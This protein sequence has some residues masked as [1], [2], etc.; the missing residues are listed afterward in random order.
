MHPAPETIAHAVSLLRRGGLVAFPTETV[1]G[2]GAD[3]F[4][5][6]AVGRV[7]ALK[8][9]PPTNPLIVHVAS[10]EM[11]RAV[12]ATWPAQ[13]EALA[14]R[15]WPGPLSL[16]LPRSPRLPDAVT[17]GSANVA[18]RMPNHPLTLALIEAF[19]SPLVGPSANRSGFVSPTRA[20]HVRD[21]F[22]PEDV[23]VLD[24][25]PCQGGIESTVVSLAEDTPRLL[26]QGPVSADEIGHALGAAIET[27]PLTV[28]P[29]A[30]APS[31]GLLASHYAP[32]TPAVLFEST[33]ELAAILAKNPRG[34]FVLARQGHTL[35]PPHA[36]EL[37]PAGAHAYA[38]RLY[39]ALRHA[40]AQG[41]SL[42]AIESPPR[43][44]EPLWLAVHDRLARATARPAT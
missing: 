6:A 35:S 31:P 24:G 27:G 22:G 42:I 39:A 18:V 10:L 15:F 37:M 36:S 8:G 21:E 34:V 20:E 40:D 26:R 5:T 28:N 2:L 30:A 25:G 33:R 14:R 38:A 16:I 7:F 19:G 44:P 3:A 41:R 4:N 9:R 29:D 13:A 32:R 1:Y 12:V 23:F 43:G 17:A 11:A